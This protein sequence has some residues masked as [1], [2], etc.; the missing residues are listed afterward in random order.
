MFSIGDKAILLPRANHMT[1]ETEWVL[2]FVGS[3]VEILALNVKSN[4]WGPYHQV[5]I[6]D[7]RKPKVAEV[8]LRKIDPQRM[9][10]ALVK[11]ADVP[12]GMPG[13]KKVKEPAEHEVANQQARPEKPVV[14][15]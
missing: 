1:K 12:G 6:G 7:G 13:E 9:D 4:Q 5:Q 11:W 15:A 14:V 10:L 3:I 2:P 8:C